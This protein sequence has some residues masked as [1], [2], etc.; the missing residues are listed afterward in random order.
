MREADLSAVAELE[1]SAFPTP[2]SAGTFQRLLHNPSVEMWVAE[3]EDRLL[4][5]GVLWCVLDQ[6]ELANLAVR[7]SARGRGLGGRILDH[8]LTVARQRNVR[9]V[10][11]EV[12]RS[13]AV[14]RRL[15]TGRGFQEVGLRPDYYQEPRED[16]LVLRLETDPGAGDGSTAGPEPPGEPAPAS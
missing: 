5:Y 8:L 6:A 1:T 15:Y 10:Y 2:W 11:L 9:S 7:P 4:G 3:E 16:A 13:N 14:A 12:R